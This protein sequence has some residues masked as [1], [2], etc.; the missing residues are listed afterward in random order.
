MAA[1][2]WILLTKGRYLGPLMFVWKNC[3][4]IIRVAGI[5]NAMTVMGPAS[6]AMCIVNLGKHCE[7]KCYILHMHV[8]SSFTVTFHSNHAI[9]FVQ[10]RLVPCLISFPKRACHEHNAFSNLNSISRVD[11]VQLGLANSKGLHIPRFLFL[12]LRRFWFNLA[13]T[14]CCAPNSVSKIMLK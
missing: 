7:K 4:A 5:L 6:N 2:W 1:H 10:I 9:N 3:W 12:K 11:K 14:Y 8:I 13:Y